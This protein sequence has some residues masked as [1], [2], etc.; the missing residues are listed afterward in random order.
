MRAL[1]ERARVLL[2]A[3]Q[4]IAADV[5]A[6]LRRVVQ[7]HAEHVAVQETARGGAVGQGDVVVRAHRRG[8]AIRNLN[9]TL[10]HAEV[11]RHDGRDAVFTEERTRRRRAAGQNSCR[12]DGRRNGGGTDHTHYY[13]Q[14]AVA[15]TAL[16]EHS[17]TERPTASVADFTLFS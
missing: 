14:C 9:R 6:A 13:L 17:L 3:G 12:R 11:S 2:S 4:R 16:P 1:A 5:V 10:R 15:R 7:T 8:L